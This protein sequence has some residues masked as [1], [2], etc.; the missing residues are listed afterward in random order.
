[1]PIISV[2]GS[3]G[4][5][6]TLMLTMLGYEYL[7]KDKYKVLSNYTLKYEHQLIELDFILNAVL[8]NL[9][10]NKCII[11]YNEVYTWLE[12]KD[13]SNEI[14]KVFSYFIMQSRKRDVTIA[15]SSQLDSMV[16]KRL[17]LLSQINIECYH[18]LEDKCFNYVFYVDGREPIIFSL[19]EKSLYEYNIFDLYNTKEI[20]DIRGREHAKGNII[21]KAYEFFKD[22]PVFKSINQM[23]SVII[24][25]N[26]FPVLNESQCRMIYKMIENETLAKEILKT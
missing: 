6:K 26:K 15:Y 3:F 17:R 14:N 23:E 19:S 7:T 22:N 24:I 4:S 1:M 10:L 16:D 11:L 18:N 9:E 21:K 25:K 5:G 12:S 13:S 8:E 20:V 2:N